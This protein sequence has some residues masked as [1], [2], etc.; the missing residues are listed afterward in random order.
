MWE[1]GKLKL[2]VKTACCLR[3]SKLTH[4]EYQRLLKNLLKILI[5]WDNQRDNSL[6]YEIGVIYYQYTRSDMFRL[7]NLK[8]NVD[9]FNGTINLK[10]M[11]G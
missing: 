11:F 9:E 3:I 1:G 6:P 5:R 7:F 10:N 8:E 4:C 2:S